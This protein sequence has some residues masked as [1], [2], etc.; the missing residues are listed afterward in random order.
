MEFKVNPN[1]AQF[2]ALTNRLKSA[3]GKANAI[4][5]TSLRRGAKPLVRDWKRKAREHKRTGAM[6]RSFGTYTRRDGI[7]IGV[8]YNFQDK[9]TGKIPN[10]YAAQAN[11]AQ[12]DWFGEIWGS[13]KHVITDRTFKE[14]NL[15]LF[16]KGF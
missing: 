16:K 7:R 13:H 5:K 6:M 12:G 10:K 9:K 8:R 15:H 3:G 11:A 1:E 2:R 14:L 4:M